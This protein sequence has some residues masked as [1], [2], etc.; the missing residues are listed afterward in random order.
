MYKRQ[1][2][3]RPVRETVDDDARNGLNDETPE[4]RCTCP[5]SVSLACC[6]AA[7]RCQL[8]IVINEMVTAAMRF[9]IEK[10]MADMEDTKLR[11][12]SRSLK[13]LVQGQRDAESRTELPLRLRNSPKHGNSLVSATF[14]ARSPSADQLQTSVQLTDRR[15]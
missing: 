15:R 8:A 5:A 14:L 7:H 2:S 12:D 6:A 4:T 3:T 10:G 13:N 9:W 11:L 1:G